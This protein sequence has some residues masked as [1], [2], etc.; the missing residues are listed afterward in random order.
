MVGASLIL[1][2]RTNKMKNKIKGINPFTISQESKNTEIIRCMEFIAH[3]LS[4]GLSV[5]TAFNQ[6]TQSY[7]F[8]IAEAAAKYLGGV[9]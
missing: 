3:Q 8:H 2:K 5:K 9:K 1:K 4:T 6:A 7:S